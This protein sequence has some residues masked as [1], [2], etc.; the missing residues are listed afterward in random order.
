MQRSSSISTARSSNSCRGP[1]AAALL[2]R[3]ARSPWSAAGG[4]RHRSAVRAAGSR[5]GRAAWRRVE[6]PA[7]G[8]R[9]CFTGNRA[10]ERARPLEPFLAAHPG[11]HVERKGLST[12][13]QYRAG[14]M[15]RHARVI[16]G[17]RT[18]CRDAQSPRLASLLRRARTRDKGNV[19]EGL[20]SVAPFAGR[21][22]V[23]SATTGRRTRVRAV[24][25]G[26]GRRSASA[27]HA[28]RSRPRRGYPAALREWLTRSLKALA[29]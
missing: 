9:L 2:L 15:G 29:D 13:F 4:C 16:G 3:Q 18:R 5:R 27:R 6:T 21:V 17:G 24:L 20:M 7:A 11:I 22:P 25:A 28:R 1:C 10:R 8:T 26:K 12:A 23:M 14:R 19:V